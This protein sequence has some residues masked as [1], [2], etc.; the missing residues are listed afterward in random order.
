V[1]RGERHAIEIGRIPGGH[2]QPPRVRVAPDLVQHP[3]DLIDRAAVRAGPGAPLLTVDRA[4]VATL[5]G[6]FVPDADAVLAQIGD[7]GVPL[8]EPEQFV[9]DGF[10]VQPLGSDERKSFRE[11][12]AHLVAE[13]GQGARAGAIGLGVA[14]VEDAPEE[15]VVFLHLCCASLAVRRFSLSH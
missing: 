5:V 1:A 3:R 8:Q 7:I 13:D 2:D 12:E 9:N 11:V 6:P 10:Q 15:V 4:E 14:L